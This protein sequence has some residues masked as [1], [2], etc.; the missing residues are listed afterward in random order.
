MYLIEA[1]RGCQHG[2]RFCMVSTAFSPMRFRPMDRILVQAWEGLKYRRRIGL[3]G[4][5]V[6]DHPNIVEILAK[7]NETGAEISVSSLRIGSLSDAILTEMSRGKARTIAIAPEAG[8]TRLR[9]VINKDISDEQILEAAD[10]IADKGFSQLKLYFILG[11]P[12]ETDEDMEGIIRLTTAIKERLDRCS[13]NTRITLT[14]APFVP[15]AG[16]PFQWLPMAPAVVLNDHLSILRSSL[17]LK[18]IR[19]NEESPAWS[20]IQGALARGDS[21]LANVL[22]NT[23]EVSL[24]GWRKAVETCVIDI[25]YFVDRRW[26]TETDLPWSI[27]DPGIKQARL[28]EEL[29]KALAIQ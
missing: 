19:L 12:T 8:S 26:T 4:P 10:M 17:P 3:V 7:L 6:A 23:E 28:C 11:L 13:G 18:G 15:K 2:C 27:I 14:A 21:R 9:Q 29:E 22:E 5:A 16:T 1:E 20:R 24:A 25:D